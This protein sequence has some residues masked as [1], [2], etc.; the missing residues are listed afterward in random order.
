MTGKCRSLQRS[1]YQI[2]E[3]DTNKDDMM[4]MNPNRLDAP[5]HISSP[6][7][8]QISAQLSP[9]TAPQFDGQDFINLESLRRTSGVQHPLLHFFLF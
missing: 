4:T 9:G 8:T 1:L 3:G 2:E 7:L 6:P 5:G